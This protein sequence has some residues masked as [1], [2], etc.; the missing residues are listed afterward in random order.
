MVILTSTC[1]RC[2][3]EPACSGFEFSVLRSHI[4]KACR[5]G[6]ELK[7]LA[8]EA[9]LNPEYEVER[10]LANRQGLRPDGTPG[11]KLAQAIVRRDHHLARVIGEPVI[12]VPE[13]RRA[14]R[15]LVPKPV[16]KMAMIIARRVG[17]LRWLLT[18]GRGA[19]DGVR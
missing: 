3:G 5:T 7:A 2:G 17:F 6:D 9:Y 15:R 8:T 11:P 14:R 18:P 4:C 12:P 16:H 19:A 10:L 13:L 1:E